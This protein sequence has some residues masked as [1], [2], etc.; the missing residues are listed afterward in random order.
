MMVQRHQDKQGGGS[1]L[2]VLIFSST[3]RN[4]PV[5]DGWWI[6]IVIQSQLRVGEI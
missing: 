1:C 3:G 2:V 4:Q 6:L 5:K